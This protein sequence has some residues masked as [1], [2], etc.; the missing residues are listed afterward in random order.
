MLSTVAARFVVSDIVLRESLYVRRG[1]LGDDTDE[2]E[3]IELQGILDVGLLEVVASDD[4]DELMTFIDLT[5]LI[6][7]GEAMSIALAMHRG[8]FVMTDD[9]KARRLL[10]EREIACF[11]SLELVRHWSIARQPAP[12]EV[13]AILRAIEQ[14]ARWVPWRAHPLAGW[15]KQSVESDA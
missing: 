7:E 11:S 13:Q 10:L 9:R 8:W 2:R 4:D 6:E 14:R 3:T 12:S 15:W 1:G 5:T